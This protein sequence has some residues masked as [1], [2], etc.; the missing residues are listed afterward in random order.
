MLSVGM[1]LCCGID[2]MILGVGDT[3]DPDLFPGW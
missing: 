2:D 1:K 3:F